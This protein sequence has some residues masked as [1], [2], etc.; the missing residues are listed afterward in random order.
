MKHAGSFRLE[1]SS[2]LIPSLR[3]AQMPPASFGSRTKLSRPTAAASVN[4]PKSNS[5]KNRLGSTRKW[6]AN[7]ARAAKLYKD[8][9]G[10][11][12]DKVPDYSPEYGMI[13]TAE[14]DSKEPGINGGLLK[15]PAQAP[16]KQ[17]G[18]NAFVCTIQVDDFDG[19]A[20]KILAAGG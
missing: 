14:K 12:I 20:K 4:S 8:I 3:A 2:L 19:I 6:L 10:W 7:T 5:A 1:A 18:S 13:M 15:R 9:F 11:S 16:E 17:C